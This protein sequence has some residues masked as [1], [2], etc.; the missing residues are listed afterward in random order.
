MRCYHL[1]APTTRR[2]IRRTKR[3]TYN[4]KRTVSR[5]L[6]IAHPSFEQTISKQAFTCFPAVSA[7]I[8]WEWS[9]A[10]MVA[11]AKIAAGRLNQLDR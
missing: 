11:H 8:H 9:A 3:P 5:P 2:L 7:D 1:A 10:L 4:K 6:S